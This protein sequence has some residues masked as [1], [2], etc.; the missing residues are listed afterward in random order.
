MDR[1][2]GARREKN[3]RPENADAEG[4]MEN[5]MP[6]KIVRLSYVR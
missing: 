2:N 6:R 5:K 1:K 4:R 3:G